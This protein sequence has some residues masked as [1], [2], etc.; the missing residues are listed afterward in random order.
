MS[1]YGD[2]N[3]SDGDYDPWYYVEETYQAAVR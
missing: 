2:G 1:D 3:Y